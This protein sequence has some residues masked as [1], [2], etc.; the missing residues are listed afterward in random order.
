MNQEQYIRAALAALQT[1]QALDV[2]AAIQIL[3]KALVV[4]PTP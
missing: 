1:G 3:R 4:S 2:I